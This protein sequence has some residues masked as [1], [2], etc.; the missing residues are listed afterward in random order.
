MCCRGGYYTVCHSHYHKCYQYCMYNTF[1]VQST[2]LSVASIVFKYDYSYLILLIL[3]K[4]DSCNTINIII[5]IYDHS[6]S[7]VS[8]SLFQYGRFV[9]TLSILIIY[10]PVLKMAHYGNGTLQH[11]P[12]QIHC[13]IHQQCPLQV[14]AMFQ[15][16]STNNRLPGYPHHPWDQMYI[17]YY[18]MIALVIF[19]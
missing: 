4:C 8:L 14:P 12:H 16:M 13:S 10:F 6:L 1:L 18:Q 15:L 3:A 2:S 17:V 9:S 7:K 19:L 11:I 5:P